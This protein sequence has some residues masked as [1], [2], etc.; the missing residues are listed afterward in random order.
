MDQWA[1]SFEEK[2]RR[3]KR[4][5]RR[6]RLLRGALITIVLTALIGAAFWAT[7]EILEPLASL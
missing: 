7:L 2:S 4:R 1:A 6:E 5:N 3:R